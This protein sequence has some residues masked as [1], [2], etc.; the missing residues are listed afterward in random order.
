MSAHSCASCH[1]IRFACIAVMML[2][3]VP[4]FSAPS[5]ERVAKAAQLRLVEVKEPDGQILSYRHLAG[6]TEV[7]MRGTRSHVS[8]TRT[9]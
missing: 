9:K 7:S 5:R 3:S 1:A 6:S 8:A 4:V 2:A